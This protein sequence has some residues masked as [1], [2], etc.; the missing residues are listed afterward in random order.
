MN[1]RDEISDPLPGIK[2][3]QQGSGKGNVES[4]SIRTIPPIVWLMLLLLFPLA[5]FSRFV[6]T[7]GSGFGSSFG[8]SIG[9]YVAWFIIGL[10]VLRGP[11]EAV[12]GLLLSLLLTLSNPYLFSAGEVAL[13]ARWIILL[14]ATIR[15][16]Y[17]YTRNPVSLPSWSMYL[18][19]FVTFVTI[20]SFFT[21]SWPVISLTRLLVFFLLAIVS[22]IGIRLGNRNWMATLIAFGAVTVIFSLPLL[23]SPIGYLRNGTQFQGILSHPQS[24]GVIISISLAAAIGYWILDY[25]AHVRWYHVTLILVMGAT[26]VLSGARSGYLALLLAL[27][28]SIILHKSGSRAISRFMFNP[29][30]YFGIAAILLLILLQILKPQ[31]MLRDFIFERDVEAYSPY[32]L[33]IDPESSVAAY[34]LASRANLFARSWSNFLEHP[35]FGIGFGIPSTSASIVLTTH[36]SGIPVSL[37]YEKGV[38]VAATLEEVGIVGSALLFLMIV[39]QFR[40]V[41][42]A[43]RLSALLLFLTALFINLGEAIYFAAGGI[44]VLIHIAI[45]VSLVTAERQPLDT[46]A[47][48]PDAQIQDY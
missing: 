30:T 38:I 34:F 18:L 22:Y 6:A 47:A 2:N 5:F 36:V 20:S 48:S 8:P 4:L 3:I 46:T 40:I 33:V 17:E 13:V 16:G 32:D 10:W 1:M 31:N 37:P 39:G 24:Y 14:L 11:D 12:E 7:T 45:A 25:D 26:L 19:L 27:I 21:S 15:V 29:I 41:R 44:G 42:K 43:A 28:I 35:L 23:Q 9:A